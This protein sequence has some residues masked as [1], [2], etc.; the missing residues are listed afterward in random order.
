MEIDSPEVLSW[1]HSLHSTL[2]QPGAAAGI[3][4]FHFCC[5]GY[6]AAVMVTAM[7]CCQNSILEQLEE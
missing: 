6:K 1:L 4:K 2:E 3:N 7:F 5:H